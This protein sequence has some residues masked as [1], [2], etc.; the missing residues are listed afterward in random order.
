MG[1][2][3]KLQFWV[4][5][6]DLFGMED[7]FVCATL[8]NEPPHDKTNKMACAPSEGSVQAELSL[9]WAHSHFVGFVMRRLICNDV[10][11]GHRGNRGNRGTIRAGTKDALCPPQL[12]KPGILARKHTSL[13]FSTLMSTMVAQ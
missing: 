11:Q 13:T 8:I 6:V 10:Y 9:R 5:L 1:L 4:V 2:E 3:S 7:V 12:W